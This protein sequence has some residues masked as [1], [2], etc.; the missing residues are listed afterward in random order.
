MSH[1][2]GI[3]TE[4]PQTQNPKPSRTSLHDCQAKTMETSARKQRPQG[5]AL[6][7]KNSCPWV[8]SGK[9]QGPSRF[10][11]PASPTGQRAVQRQ[12]NMGL[13]SLRLGILLG[14]C[15]LVRYLLK[16]LM[17]GRL[18]VFIQTGVSIECTGKRQGPALGA[19]TMSGMTGRFGR[20]NLLPK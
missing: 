4:Q 16:T 15:V 6:T 9:S 12:S 14:A 5:M 13:G 2:L 17:R 20:R 11:T 1:G 18:R 10:Q 7:K 19:S 8:P 3:Q